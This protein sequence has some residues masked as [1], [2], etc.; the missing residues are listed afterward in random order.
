MTELGNNQKLKKK[1]CQ[2]EETK[3]KLEKPQDTLSTMI[4]PQKQMIK[5]LY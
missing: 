1:I 5:I 3:T 2:I 4:T